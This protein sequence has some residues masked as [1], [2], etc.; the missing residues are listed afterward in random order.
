MYYVFPSRTIE[1]LTQKWTWFLIQPIN[2]NTF[3]PDKI[4]T[5]KIL[6]FLYLFSSIKINIILQ[7]KINTIIQF[8]IRNTSTQLSCDTHPN[9]LIIPSHFH[10]PP[11]SDS[12]RLS[13]MAN[14]HTQAMQDLRKDLNSVQSTLTEHIASAANLDLNRRREESKR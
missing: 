9:Q 2:I 1:Y 7:I 13:I 5:I 8:L 12:G 4:I 3:Y 6:F 11:L 14:P 10:L